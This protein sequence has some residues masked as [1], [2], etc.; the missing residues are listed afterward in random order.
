MLIAARDEGVRCFVMAGSSSAYGNP[1][2]LPS[3]ETLPTNPLSPYAIS[4]VAGEMFAQSFYRLHGLE[5]VV[6]R[7]FNVFGPRQ[8]PNSPY[9]AVVP[10][11]ISLFLDDRSPTIYGDG[12]QS[13][14][15]DHVKNVVQANLLAC[16]ASGEAAGEIFNCASGESMSISHLA[17]E[18][19]RLTSATA[20]VQYGPARDGEVHHSQADI[21][22][23]GRLLSYRPTVKPLEGLQMLVDWHRQHLA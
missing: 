4:K 10:R 12:S 3:P 6:L 19:R 11:F 1:S 2:L 9:S 18:L 13:R 16:A 20:E 8:D 17:E 5:T 14:D 23:A 7:Y 21:S 15:F 22:K